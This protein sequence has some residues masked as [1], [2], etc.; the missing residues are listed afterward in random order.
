MGPSRR[1]D[2]KG[3]S[4]PCAADDAITYTQTTCSTGAFFPPQSSAAKCH[5]K[6]LLSHLASLYPTQA[7]KPGNKNWTTAKLPSTGLPLLEASRPL[8]AKPWSGTVH[9]GSNQTPRSTS[10]SCLKTPI[11]WPSTNPAGDPHL[12]GG[13]M[14]NTLLRRVQKQTPN[15]NPVHRLGR[16]TTGIVLFAKTVQAALV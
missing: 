3:L 9:R 4:G 15:A 5:G 11:C 7:H 1:L 14:E 8:Q 16:A 6:T 12:G 10:K 13:F 2:R